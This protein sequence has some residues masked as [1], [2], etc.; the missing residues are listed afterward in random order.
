M[1]LVWAHA[2]YVKLCRSLQ[3]LH[4]F[5]MP[6]QTVERYVI[7]KTGSPH[8]I[9]SFGDRCR[10]MPTGK[11]LRLELFSPAMVHWSGDGWSTFQDVQAK[12]THLGIYVADLPT[13]RFPAGTMVH[14]TFY[15][16]EETRWEKVDYSVIVE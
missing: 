6:P 16:S 7:K 1:P 13:D 3:E 14:F 5:D 2:E 11:V 15:W 4:V 9:W 8:A 12:D 10:A